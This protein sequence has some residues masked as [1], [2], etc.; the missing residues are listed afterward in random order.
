MVTKQE[1]SSQRINVQGELERGSEVAGPR[2]WGWVFEI[3]R[4]LKNSQSKG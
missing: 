1:K 2:F 3:Y 4:V